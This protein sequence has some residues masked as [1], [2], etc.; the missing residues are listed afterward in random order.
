MLFDS[1]ARRLTPLLVAPAVLASVS[2][3]ALEIRL[4]AANAVNGSVVEIVSRFE[5]TSGHKVLFTWGSSPEI[6]KR[7]GS[8]EAFDVAILTSAS[9]DKL[10]SEGKLV[11]QSRAVFAKTG[12][13]VAVR[14]G[15]PR[16]DISTADAVKNAVLAAKSVGYSA[17]TSGIYLA[18]LFKRMGIAEQIKE[19]VRRPPSGTPVGELVA[20]G[21]VDLG[22][23]QASELI[24]IKGIDYLGPLPPEIQTVTAYTLGL[25]AS[26]ASRDA[27]MGLIKTLTSPESAAIIRKNGMDPP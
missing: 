27:A 14:A 20:R 1:I 26:S 17:G 10:I 11:G 21:E 22:F 24:H 19:K 8:G 15:Q 3:Q 25:N 5:Q 2:A 12:V 23:Q 9:I 6:A 13:G 4:L 7:V 18:D 16:P